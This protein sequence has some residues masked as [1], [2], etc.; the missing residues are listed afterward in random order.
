MAI[1]ARFLFDVK[2][3]DTKAGGCGATAAPSLP[4]LVTIVT[5]AIAREPKRIS[6]QGRRE[7]AELTALAASR[8]PRQDAE[9]WAGVDAVWHAR[10]ADDV[11]RLRRRARAARRRGREAMADNALFSAVASERSAQWAEWR[12]RSVALGRRDLVDTCGTRTL[13]V[14][15]GCGPITLPVGCGIGMLCPRCSATTW[16]KWRR[17]IGTALT[18][19]ER[20]AVASWGVR[21]GGGHRPGIFLITLT[22]PHSGDLVADRRRMAAAWRKLSK[23]ASAGDWWG[24]HVVAWEATPGADG[25]GHVHLHAA[26]VSSWVPYVAVRDVWSRAVGVSVAHVNFSPPRTASRGTA[27]AAARYVAK[28][29][30]K[31]VQPDGMTAQKVGELLVAARNR[32]KVTTSTHFFRPVVR[33]PCRKCGVGHTLE[34]LPAALVTAAPAACWRAF[35]RGVVDTPRTQLTAQVLTG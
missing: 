25:Q 30:S 17:R 16:R 8:E 28:Y 34:A 4:N 32:R 26:V 27:Y 19:H 6:V 5:T 2:T 18:A 33:K 13:A 14:R 7:V 20:A 22:A 3:S 12:A 23:A 29:V 35:V 15:C 9:W 1:D 10:T 11:A 31:G 21:G 24:H